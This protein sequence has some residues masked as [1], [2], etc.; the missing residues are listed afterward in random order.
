MPEEAR[1]GRDRG[2]DVAVLKVAK[3]AFSFEEPWSLADSGESVSLVDAVTGKRPRLTTSVLAVYDDERL[4]VR[5]S[6]ED[7]EIVATKL[8]R[9]DSLYEE[10]VVELFLAPQA[11]TRYFEFE[12]NPLG[13][14]FDAVVDSPDLDRRTM[15]VDR[16]W[17]AAALRTAIRRSRIGSEPW[18]FETILSI[19]FSDLAV[20]APVAGDR[21]AA[22]FFRIDR[23]ARGDDEYSAWVPALRDPADF[24]VP[25][26]FGVLEFV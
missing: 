20:A 19:A 5:F 21:F 10:D 22:G 8:E 1:V 3:A 17:N 7:D 18:Q 12:V 26:K 14:V 25:E 9:D 15:Q 24:H 23:S 6:G 16:A 4:T 13:T 11:L 2:V